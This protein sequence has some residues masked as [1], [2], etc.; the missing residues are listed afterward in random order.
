[1]M[2][3]ARNRINALILQQLS[4]DEVVARDPMSDY[5]EQWGGGFMSGENFTRLAYQSLAHAH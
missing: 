1:M 5:H 2:M 4:E 3:T